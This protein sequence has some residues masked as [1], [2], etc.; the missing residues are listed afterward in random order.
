M[1]T[2]VLTFLGSDGKTRSFKISKLARIPERGKVM[3]I[4]KFLDGSSFLDDGIIKGKYKTFQDA[5]VVY[6]QADIYFR[7][8]E[9]S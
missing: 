7:A 2:L 3:D 4:A 5:T 8:N 1:Y 6:N 9:L